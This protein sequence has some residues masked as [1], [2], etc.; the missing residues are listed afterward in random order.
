[1]YRATAELFDFSCRL[2]IRALKKQNKI[3]VESYKKTLDS[4]AGYEY[5]AE[6]F[7]EVLLELAETDLQTLDWT[8]EQ[9][10]DLEAYLGLQEDLKTWVAQQL[11]DLEY[12]PGEDFSATCDGKI[13]IK[14]S[15]QIG[16]LATLSPSYRVLMPS[17]LQVVE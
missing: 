7:I 14:E 12:V 15:V 5:T 10:S 11:I 8:L 9:F 6:I 4:L 16:L 17:I 1:M 2:I 3:L 13:L